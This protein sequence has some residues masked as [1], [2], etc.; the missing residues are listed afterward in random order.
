MHTNSR[1]A[2]A[3]GEPLTLE[4]FDVD[5]VAQA[6]VVRITEK[7]MEALSASELRHKVYRIRKTEDR[8]CPFVTIAAVMIALANDGATEAELMEVEFFFAALRQQLYVGNAHR[9]L[10]ELHLEETRH[11]AIENEETMLVLLQGED[12]EQLE[13]AALAKRKEIATETEV[14]CQM[15]RRAREIRRRRPTPRSGDFMRP[16]GALAAGAGR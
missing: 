15:E 10:R 6:L 7:H 3:R 4:D 11:E 8:A 14:A 2:F 5:R 16:L 9:C 13:R 12:P 1:A